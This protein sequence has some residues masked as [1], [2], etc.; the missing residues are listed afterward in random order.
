[1]DD[2]LLEAVVHQVCG[3]H[4]GVQ[5]GPLTIRAGHLV[6]A[7]QRSLQGVDPGVEISTEQVRDRDHAGD[8]RRCRTHLT[9]RRDQ[10][11]SPLVGLRGGQVVVGRRGL[12]TERGEHPGLIQGRKLGRQVA[13]GPAAQLKRLAMSRHRTGLAGGGY[14]VLV[15]GNGTTRLLEVGR[16]ERAAVAALGGGESHL[17]VQAAPQRQAGVGVQGVADQRV[18]EVE[19]DRVS[20]GQDEIG[21]LQLTQGV[22]HLVRA[23]AGHRGKQVEVEGAP[24]DGRR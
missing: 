2:G 1:M 21:L 24:D 23:C 20:T 7:V 17:L 18:P 6:Q 16:D 14:G 12:V 19:G 15:G 13:D 8:Q 9:G 11:M 10:L 3:R 22:G 4:R 5:P